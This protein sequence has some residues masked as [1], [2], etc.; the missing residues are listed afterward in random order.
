MIAKKKYITSRVRISKKKKWEKR[1]DMV[2]E[3]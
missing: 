3:T 1:Q 2:G